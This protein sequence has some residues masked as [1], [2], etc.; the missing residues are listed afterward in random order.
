MPGQIDGGDP[1]P[2]MGEI[3]GLQLPNGAVHTGTV[4]QHDRWKGWV[5]ASV[6]VVYLVLTVYLF[7]IA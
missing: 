3:A 7:F 4:H 6:Y 5:L 2:V 1:K